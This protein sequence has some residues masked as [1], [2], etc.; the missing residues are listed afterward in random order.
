MLDTP[1]QTPCEDPC[2]QHLI[3]TSIIAVSRY[4]LRATF[5]GGVFQKRRH[6]MY[7]QSSNKKQFP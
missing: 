2:T 3:I 4:S 7:S 1:C 5:L 6:K